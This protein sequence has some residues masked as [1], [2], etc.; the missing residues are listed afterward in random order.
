M[1][2]ALMKYETIDAEQI[3]DIMDGRTPRPPEGWDESEPRAGGGQAGARR[4][5]RAGQP[6]APSATPAGQ[7]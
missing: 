6:R 2:D 1:A 7:H 3:D 5:T 4:R